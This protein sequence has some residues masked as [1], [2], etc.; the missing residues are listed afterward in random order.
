MTAGALLAAAALAAAPRVAVDLLARDAPRGAVVRG[1]GGAFSVAVRGD[2]LL[3]DGRP[4]PSL[5]LAPGA[6]EIAPDRGPARTYRAALALRARRGVLAVRAE[7]DLDDYVAAVVA[8]ETTPDTPPAAL[9]AQA[10]VV[11]SYALAARE[12]HPGG[13]LCDLAH[14]QVLR[15][16]GTPA[17]HLRAAEEAARATAGEVL[18]LA[19]GA[20]AEATFHAA[21]GGHTADPLEAFGS[22]ATGAAAA[23][24]PGCEGPPW[25]A[26]VEPRVLAGAV[27]GALAPSDVAGAAAVPATLRAADLTVVGGRGGWAVRVA[28]RG[29]R[30]ALGG[31]AFARALDAALGRGAVRSSRLSLAD[32]GGRVVVRGT[33]HGHGVGLCQRG[34]ARWAARGEG[35]REIL[36]RYFA[37]RPAVERNLIGRGP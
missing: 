25:R 15:A 18:R 23:P 31:D 37:A 14:C 19:S 6:W 3:V 20:V 28:G 32:A 7:M 8:S 34:A 5:A 26:A 16:H 9:R 12:R 21:C 1:A 11:R 10:V 33:G 35:H 22:G 27:R 24:D 2:G 30:W 17:R 13:A 4:L 29:S 36:A